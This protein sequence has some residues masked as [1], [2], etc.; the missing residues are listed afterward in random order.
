MLIRT[1]EYIRRDFFLSRNTTN[2][3]IFT[4]VAPCII[5]IIKRIAITAG[6]IHRPA[7]WIYQKELFKNR[8]IAIE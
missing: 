3:D 6:Q 8:I 1:V 4:H 5:G 2:F 7:A